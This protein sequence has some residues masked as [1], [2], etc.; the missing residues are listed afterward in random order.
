MHNAEG[1]LVLSATDLVGHLECEHLTRLERMAA[2]G[3]VK[4]PDREDP[5]L[6]LLSTLGEE[7]E[8]YHL[9]RYAKS[10][11]NVV[12]VEQRAFTVDQLKGAEAQTVQAMRDGADVIYQGTFFDGRWTGRADFLIKVTQPSEL[13]AH[14]Y[15]VVDAKLARHAK[16]RALL[17]VA[18]YSDQLTRLQGR[19]PLNMRL[20]LGDHTEQVF[21]VDDF[22]SYARIALTRLETVLAESLLPTY[23]DKVH[24]CDICRWRDVCDQKRRDDDHLSLVAGIRRDQIR[25]L[26][27]AS[28][29]TTTALAASTGP[30]EGIGQSALERI[31]TQ[32]EL[33]I[34]ALRTGERQYALVQEP[35]PGLGLGALPEPS[36]GDL[37]F[38][39]EGDPYVAEGG[40]EYLFGVARLEDEP[41]HYKS[42]WAHD[43][44]AEKIAFEGFVDFAMDRWQRDPNLHIY[45]YASYETEALKRLMGR[46]GTR[47]NEIDRMLRGG[48]FVDLYQVLRQGVRIS[49]EGYSLKNVERFYRPKRTESVLDAG[50]SIVEYERWRRE[51]DDKVLVEIERY[52]QSDCESTSQLRDW[53]EERRTEAIGY[54][55]ALSR[56]DRRDPEPAPELAAAEAAVHGLAEALLAGVPDAPIE[57]DHEE[58]AR[59]LLAQSLS[60]HRR[61]AKADW[62]AYFQRLA[63]TDDELIADT[64]GQLASG[65]VVYEGAL[66]A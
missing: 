33:Q 13:G 50:T 24:H 38:D 40:L 59:W 56:P 41:F 60:W 39:M 27:A 4:R 42:W 47:E 25:R 58:Q 66:S 44:T 14:S 19:Q 52:N 6:D 7:H 20:I 64:E 62:W 2:L 61:E 37:F 45:H 29:P 55:L 12:V 65:H 31:R 18:I 22:A 17:Q 48:L 8:R 36:A 3:E 23:P 10:G 5:A 30:V 34:A 28:I 53:L 15:E 35:T 57:R 63:M 16:T 21:R 54:G 32:A 9:E 1:V 11:L 51:G 49:E 46:H 26:A 43:R